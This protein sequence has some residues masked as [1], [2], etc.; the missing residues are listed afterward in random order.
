MTAAAAVLELSPRN[1]VGKV[2]KQAQREQLSR[3]E[4]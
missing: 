1:P 2:L 3:E 4:L